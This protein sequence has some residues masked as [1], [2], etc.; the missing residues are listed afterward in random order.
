MMR[1]GRYVEGLL[2]PL[3][4]RSFRMAFVAFD[5]TL[6]AISPLTPST[7]FQHYSNALALV[8]LPRSDPTCQWVAYLDTM[9]SEE[10]QIA[11]YYHNELTDETS[12]EAPPHPPPDPTPPATASE[13][14]SAGWLHAAAED[15]EEDSA[16][17]YDE[18]DDVLSDDYYDDDDDD[19]S[20]SARLTGHEVFNAA[21]LGPP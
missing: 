15:D 6:S 14:V 10:D 7:A 1:R 20:S 4:Q 3:T 21:M 12:W 9:A 17:A 18:E 19:D 16:P 2:P 8:K 11:V 5:F 13:E